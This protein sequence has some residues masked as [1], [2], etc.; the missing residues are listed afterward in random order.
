MQRVA[1]TEPLPGCNFVQGHKGPTGAERCRSLDRGW[2]VS[3]TVSR[4]RVP[5]ISRGG[6]VVCP[7]A[8]RARGSASAQLFVRQRPGGKGRAQ[9]VDQPA[10]TC[11]SVSRDQDARARLQVERAACRRGATQGA[12]PRTGVP[13]VPGSV[14]GR[15]VRAGG[16]RSACLQ[17]VAPTEPLSGCNFVQGHTGST[18]ITALDLHTRCRGR[19]TCPSARARTRSAFWTGSWTGNRR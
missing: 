12:S 15:G 4:G 17:K 18:G 9:P 3:V 10:R 19:G 7:G 2:G 5:G 14:C 13:T 6:A 11:A 8:V 16:R 1:P